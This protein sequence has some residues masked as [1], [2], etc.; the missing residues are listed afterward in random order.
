VS[1]FNKAKL[2]IE[3]TNNESSL[4]GIEIIIDELSESINYFDNTKVSKEILDNQDYIDLCNYVQDAYLLLSIQGLN[5][6]DFIDKL[7]KESK[8]DI[9]TYLDNYVYD[10]TDYETI[11]KYIIGDFKKLDKFILYLLKNYIYNNLY[12][13]LK[14]L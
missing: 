2:I 1:D 13:F 9:Y 14:N 3:K 7:K 5:V 11:E 10:D 12:N 6:Q 8:T 4:K